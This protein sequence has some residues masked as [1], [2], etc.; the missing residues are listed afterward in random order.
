MQYGND[1]N[2]HFEAWRPKEVEEND[3]T[4]YENELNDNRLL[5]CHKMQERSTTGGMH[6][7]A[8]DEEYIVSGRLRW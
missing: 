2:K 5:Y 4:D 1:E 8:V 6:V 7:L 3:F